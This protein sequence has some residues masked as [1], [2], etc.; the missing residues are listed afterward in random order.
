MEEDKRGSL[1]CG[2]WK[3]GN[4]LSQ[5]LGLFSFQNVLEDYAFRVGGAGGDP[6]GVSRP[7]ECISK[8]APDLVCGSIG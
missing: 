6:T 3:G 2:V 5:I 4:E 7:L 8:M 1:L